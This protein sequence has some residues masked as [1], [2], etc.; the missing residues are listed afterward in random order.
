MARK[1]AGLSLRGL[2]GALGGR[3]SHQ[4]IRKYEKGE[5]TPGS[6]V[7]VALARALGVSVDFLMG[8]QVRTLAGVEFRRR[9]P[10]SARDRARVEAEVID[11]VDR[12]LIVEELLELDTA[13]WTPPIPA[14]RLTDEEDAEDVAGRVRDAWDL[15]DGPI[16]NL[17]ELLEERGLKIFVIPLPESVSGLTGWIVPPDGGD[18]MPVIVVNRDHGLER[19]RFTL[20][21]ELAHRV[22]DAEA[23][24]NIECAANRFAGSFLVPAGHLRYRVSSTRH[25]GRRRI[26]Y[27]EIIRLKRIYGVSAAA[28]LMRLCQIGVLSESAM[29]YAF[30]TFANGWRGCE[31]EPLEE[32]SHRPFELPR[33]FERLCCWALA[34]RLIAPAR[35][36]Q[37]LQV[38]M[39][40]IEEAL[41]GPMEADASRHQ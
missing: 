2:S 18:H 34:E 38:P 3:P 7:L 11:Q 36:A 26:S 23:P 31:P 17:T 19:R 1:R 24:V 27:G 6:G 35:A 13:H 40:M 14:V 22:L 16:P 10:T 37:L 32:N 15:G 33:R 12:Y 29:R 39:T 20:A 28:V 9:S 21:H 4:A 8:D 30:Q 41:R 5:M 25:P